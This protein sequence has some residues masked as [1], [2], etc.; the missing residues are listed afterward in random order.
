M[1]PSGHIYK[2]GRSPNHGEVKISLSFFSRL[3]YQLLRGVGAGLIGYFI[4]NFLFL[5]GPLM[6][7]EVNYT[8]RDVE[9][10]NIQPSANLIDPAEAESTIKIQKEA[11]SFGV[12]SYFSVVIPKIEAASNVIA[13]VD[14]N[15]KG[16]YM[17]A[18]SSGV[19]HAK[20]TYFPGQDKNIFLFAHSVDSPLNIARYNAVFYLLRK[21]EVGDEIVVYFADK[22]YQYRVTDKVITEPEDTSYLTD[23]AAEEKLLLMTCDPPGTTWRRLIVI[24][25][26]K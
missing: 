10:S 19:A 15:D 2:A 23:I 5:F 26:P 18:L 1:H 17:D 25:E 4:I 3:S 22:K 20:G 16:V 11:D 12:N 9:Y 24:A 14:I 13:N 8:L 6:R 21:L 7:E